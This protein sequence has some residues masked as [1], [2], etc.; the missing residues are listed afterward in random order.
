MGLAGREARGAL[1]WWLFVLVVFDC[2]LAMST[3][4]RRGLWMWTV[5][6]FQVDSCT[7]DYIEYPARSTTVLRCQIETD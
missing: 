6:S 7:E 3:E 5:L 1:I 2:I 4:G